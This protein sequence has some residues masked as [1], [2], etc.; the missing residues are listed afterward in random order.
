M[1]F[2]N[3]EKYREAAR[4]VSFRRRVYA[5]LIGE[6]RMAADV[7]DKRIA[8]MTEIAEDFRRLAESDAPEIKFPESYK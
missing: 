8:I 3:A 7:A 1:S 2:S 4:E 5:R 6:N